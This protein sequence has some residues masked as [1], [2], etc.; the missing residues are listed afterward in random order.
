MYEGTGLAGTRCN[1][2]SDEAEACP[3]PASEMRCC[4]LGKAEDDIVVIDK[5]AASL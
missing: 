1:V 2:F 4:G 3:I 5:S